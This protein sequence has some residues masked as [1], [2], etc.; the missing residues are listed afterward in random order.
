M[1]DFRMVCTMFAFAQSSGGS[2]IVLGDGGHRGTVNNRGCQKL[3]LIP[4][5]WITST[6]RHT[7]L[8]PLTFPTSNLITLTF[9]TS[10]LIT[11]TFPTSNLFPTSKGKWV[12]LLVEVIQTGG[13]NGNSWQ[14]L[15]FT[16]PRWPPSPSMIMGFYPLHSGE[17]RGDNVFTGACPFTG[18]TLAVS[19]RKTFLF[20]EKLRAPTYSAIFSRIIH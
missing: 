15:L 12:C 3:P 8:I 16:I 13:I 2:W 6:N 1:S 5:V 20:R 4:P 9:P 17:I 11:L 10:N 7:H 14:P 18:G 19:R